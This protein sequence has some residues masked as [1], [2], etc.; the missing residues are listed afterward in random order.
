MASRQSYEPAATVVSLVPFPISEFKPGMTPDKF[1]LPPAPEGDFSTL[2]VKKCKHGVYLDENRPVL[3]VPTAPE[4]VAEAICFDYKKGQMG[5]ALDEAEPALFWVQGDY[6]ID[7]QNIDRNKRN[8]LLAEFATEFREAERK[9][10]QWF[11][12]LVASAD[13]AWSKFH[14]RGMISVPQRIAA[15][16]LKLDREWLLEAEV[17]AALSECPACFEKVHPKAILCRSCNAVLKPEEY[18][19][20]QFAKSGGVATATK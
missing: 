16:R 3:I 17:T 4:E 13:D 5:I 19:K 15:A 11:K 18:A 12:N 8:A 6:H 2:L 7:P 14:Q 1:E 20:I 9:Q 10:V